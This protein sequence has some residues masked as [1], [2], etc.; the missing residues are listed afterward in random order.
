MTGLGAGAHPVIDGDAHLL[1]YLP[2]LGDIAAELADRTTADAMLRLARSRTARLRD[3]SLQDRRAAGLWRGAWWGAPAENTLDLATSALPRLLHSRLDELGIGFSFVYPSIGLLVWLTPDAELR[4][5]LARSVNTY[6]AQAF[7]G[8]RDRLEPGAVIPMH[9]PGEAVAELE[10]AVNELGLRTA[11]MTGVVP[12]AFPGVDMPG[13]TWLDSI[14]CG[15]VHD[16]DEVWATCDRLRIVPTFHATGMGWGSRNSTTNYVFN[17]LGNFAAANEAA[18]RAVVMGGA[19]RRFPR[20]PWMFLEG[21]VSWACQL[22]A[23]LV[24]HVEKRRL[25]AIRQYDPTRVDSNLLA[26]RFREYAHPGVAARP[27]PFEDW[28][29]YL[30]DPGDGMPLIDDFAA[31]GL[32]SAADVTRLFE[33][34]FF[35]CEADDRLAPMAFARSLNAEGSQLQALLC[36]DIGHW[37][38]TDAR[39]VV[40]ESREALSTGAMTEDDYHAFSYDNVKRCYTALRPDFFE[41]TIVD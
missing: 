35:G 11:V 36:S 34:F 28:A 30:L 3:T 8:L 26:I 29:P 40:P 6:T 23:D 13:A 9:D 25:G 24:E 32:D 33:R 12:R 4:R 16:Y 38:V 14:A 2:V 17:H 10:H 39:Q 19:A 15:G 22:Q 5:L 31:S 18:C 21:G 37:D 41:G 7:A 1:E 27:V 20:L